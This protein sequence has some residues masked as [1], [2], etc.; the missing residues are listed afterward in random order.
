MRVLHPLRARR[1]DPCPTTDGI[2]N[3]LPLSVGGPISQRGLRRPVRASSLS[4]QLWVEGGN[5]GALNFYRAR[6]NTFDDESE[7][8]GLLFASHAAVAF[9]GA[10][11]MHHMREAEVT[12]DLIGQAKR[13][14]MERYKVTSDQAV[15]MLVK[16]SN[17]NN[18]ALR[19]V[20]QDLVATGLWKGRG[21]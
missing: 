19:S 16:V 7:Q 11:D 10:Q 9:A 21:S 2:C 18:R 5:L 14:L 13:I 4:V 1:R 8:V 3:G 6:V 15:R 12:R 17:D 20:A